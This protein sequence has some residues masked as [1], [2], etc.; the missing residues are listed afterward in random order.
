[1][2][3]IRTSVPAVGAAAILSL[4]PVLPAASS[5]RADVSTHRSKVTISRFLPL[6]HGKVRSAKKQCRRNRR[7]V[8]YKRRPGPDLR[9]GRDRTNRRGRWRVRVEPSSLKPNDRFY[10]KATRK[11]RII[12]GVGYDCPSARS[13]TI[14]FVGD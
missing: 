6:Y 10:A 8:L 13:R 11:L 12:S 2:Q 4:L 7:V 9:I 14:T 1:M 3:R 5:A